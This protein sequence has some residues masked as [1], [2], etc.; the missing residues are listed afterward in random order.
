MHYSVAQQKN[1]T[2]QKQLTKVINEEANESIIF[3]ILLCLGESCDM[4]ISGSRQCSDLMFICF[5]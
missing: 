3:S 4:A 2:P 1:G 5:D